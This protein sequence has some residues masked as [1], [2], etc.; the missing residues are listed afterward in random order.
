MVNESDV[1]AVDVGTVDV[2]TVDT[3]PAD[4]DAG[5]L[6]RL[7]TWAVSP[8]DAY[9]MIAEASARCPVGRSEEMG[10]FHVLLGYADVKL[11]AR[12]WQTYA[13]APGCFR[14]VLPPGAVTPLDLD[15]P[16][17]VP[18]RKILAELTNATTPARM[19]ARI[20]DEVNEVIDSFTERGEVDLVGEF[21]AEIPLRAICIAMGID[22]KHSAEF[23]ERTM[24]MLQAVTDPQLLMRLGAEFTDLMVAMVEE[25][26]SLGGDEYI[27]KVAAASID[28][29]PL[30][31][32]QLSIAL[33]N[34]I[35]PGF[36]TTIS[37]LSTLLQLVLSQAGVRQRLVEDPTLTPRAV[38]EALR[39]RPPIFGFYRRARKDLRLHGTDIPQGEDLYLC[40]AAANRDPAVFPRP[41]EFSLDRGADQRHLAFGH[42]P[43]VCP[44]APL[45][46]MEMRVALDVLL[47]RLPDIE[48]VEP[49]LPP[50]YE[51]GGAETMR[52][53]SLPAR[54]SP[55]PRLGQDTA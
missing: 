14:P 29:R 28:G 10:G 31:R 35:A 20:T 52:M 30:T 9:E 21:A 7:N 12:D 13:I 4:T 5:P 36:E 39:L 37:G 11:A 49:E 40:W 19:E 48:L 38:D 54:F 22:K 8:S 25:R 3:G 15:P 17:H 41:L 44:G 42:G 26:R 53:V 18:W 50:R 55:R 33:V 34:P 46:R 23:H 51:F 24:R 43:H 16:D 1:N 32:E 47:R 2:S 27:D 6:A 45:A